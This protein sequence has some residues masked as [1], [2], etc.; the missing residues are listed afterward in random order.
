MVQRTCPHPIRSWPTPDDMIYALGY[1]DPEDDGSLVVEVAARPPGQHRRILAAADLLSQRDR[2]R[3]VVRN[4][5]GRHRTSSRIRKQTARRKIP[6]REII[7]GP[8]SLISK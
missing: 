7:L 1:V 3:D 2:G 5:E 8:P 4:Q 6:D